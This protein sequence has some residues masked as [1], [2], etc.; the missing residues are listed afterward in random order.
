MPG[1]IPYH[2]PKY[3]RPPSALRDIVSTVILLLLYFV[4]AWISAV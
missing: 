1:E 2:L 3:K 4:L